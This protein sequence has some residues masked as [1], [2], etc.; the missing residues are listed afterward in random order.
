MTFPIAEGDEV[1]VVFTSRC[2]D[3]WWQLG[4]PPRQQAEFRMHDLSDG[5]AIPGPR[6]QPRVLTNI[7]TTGVQL[8]DD[9]G[10]TY[11][12]ITDGT[13]TLVAPTSVIVQAP[14]I[15]LEADTQVDVIAPQINLT[16]DTNVTIDSPATT[17]T[18]ALTVQGLLTYQ[19]GIAGTAGAGTNAMSGDFTLTGN[20]VQ[21]GGNLSSNGK[22]LATHTHSGVTTGGGNSGPPT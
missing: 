10:E 5:F 20:L 14:Q 9:E 13:I 17:C 3:A 22:V 4:T 19:A 21:S 11:V 18:G 12:D 7:S 6:S 16:A 8:R 2:F 1:L 15:T